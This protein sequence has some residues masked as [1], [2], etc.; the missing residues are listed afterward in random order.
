[1]GVNHGGTGNKPPGATTP[2]LYRIA[3]P[4]VCKCGAGL[5]SGTGERFIVS[6]TQ[7]DDCRLGHTRCRVFVGRMRPRGGEK[8]RETVGPLV[9]ETS[10]RQRP[11][12]TVFMGPTAVS[13]RI[14]A[15]DD[16]DADDDVS[17][18]MSTTS[19]WRT[20]TYAAVD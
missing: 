12:V 14:C 6:V 19:L 17:M 10:H 18:T 15:D 16:D 3:G 9:L 7:A 13:D 11:T 4:R 1:M 8:Q 2:Q 20:S 5:Y